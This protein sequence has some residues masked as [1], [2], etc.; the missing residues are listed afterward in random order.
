MQQSAP[1]ACAQTHAPEGVVVGVFATHSSAG[2]TPRVTAQSETACLRCSGRRGGPRAFGPGSASEGSP[3]V[4]WS[5][6]GVARVCFC[7]PTMHTMWA[8]RS[9]AQARLE[10][11]ISHSR[12]PKAY[13]SAAATASSD[14]QGDQSVTATSC[15]LNDGRC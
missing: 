2:S 12:T 7:T 4:G 14:A 8:W 13:T 15:L 3:W 5:P 10:V 6:G 11:S 9:P 1:P